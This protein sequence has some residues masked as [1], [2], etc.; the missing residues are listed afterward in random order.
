[1]NDVVWKWIPWY[2][3]ES[4]KAWGNQ[5]VPETEVVL[6]MVDAVLKDLLVLVMCCISLVLL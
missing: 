6:C 1:M 3:R 5:Q 2:T 4:G